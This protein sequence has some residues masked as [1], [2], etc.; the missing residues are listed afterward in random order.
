VTSEKPQKGVLS[1]YLRYYDGALQFVIAVVL[2]TTGGYWVDGRLGTKVLFT[3][4]GFALGFAGGLRALYKN[5]CGDPRR[6]ER[7]QPGA[8]RKA[9]RGDD[10]GPEPP[11]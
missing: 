11:E 10:A 4:L 5:F 3:L 8:D 2:F 7:D 9:E 1:K 6:P